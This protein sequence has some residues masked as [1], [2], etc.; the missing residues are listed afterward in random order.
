MIRIKPLNPDYRM[1]ASKFLSPIGYQGNN[2]LCSDWDAEHMEKLDYNGLYEYLYALKNGEKFD[3]SKFPDGIPSADFEAVMME[4]LPVTVEQ[5]RQ[6]AAFNSDHQTYKWQPLGCGNYT[7]N[8]F[9]TSSP[10]VEERTDNP[11][12]TVTLTI[13]AVCE[14][15]GNDAAITHK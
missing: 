3:G 11:D 8:L 5:L 13:N 7:P 9:V 14:E 12:G 4:Y 2:L 10:E 6:Y 1:L 15:A